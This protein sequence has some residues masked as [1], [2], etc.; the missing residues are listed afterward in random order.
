MGELFPAWEG[1]SP[2]GMLLEEALASWEVVLFP[3]RGPELLPSWE[4]VSQEGM[5]LE[6]ALAAW[7]VVLSLG[8]GPK[9]FLGGGFPGRIAVACLPA[10][11]PAYEAK[12]LPAW[13]LLP[14]WERP[15][16]EGVLLTTCL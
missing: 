11:L 1:P 15:P 2:E 4:V 8:R 9:L 16:W 3:G 14:S 7:E 12:L 5:L 10:C 13:E 6:E